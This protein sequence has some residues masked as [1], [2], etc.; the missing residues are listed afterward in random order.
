MENYKHLATLINKWMHSGYKEEAM[1]FLDAI[2]RDCIS[3]NSCTKELEEE[4]E[5]LKTKVDELEYEVEEL[6]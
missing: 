3:E 5:D 2:K 6:K 1:E 4:I